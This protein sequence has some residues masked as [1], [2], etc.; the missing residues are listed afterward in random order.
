MEKL[1]R[2]SALPSFPQ[3]RLLLR[4]WICLSCLYPGAKAPILLETSFGTSKQ[5]AE[6]VVHFSIPSRTVEFFHFKSVVLLLIC[7]SGDPILR[8]P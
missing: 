8:P 4:A 6:K 7:S 2:W 3:P 1:E 5:L